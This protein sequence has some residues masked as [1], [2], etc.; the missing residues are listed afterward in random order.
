VLAGVALAAGALALGGC[1]TLTRGTHGPFRIVST[2][3]GAHVQLSSGET[4]VTP[5]TLD[6]PR[7]N[8]FEA[9]LTLAGYVTQTLSVTSRGS[10]VGVIG[11]L[12]NGVIGGMAGAGSDMDSGALRSLSPNPLVVRFDPVPSPSTPISIPPTMPAP[13]SAT[14][15]SPPVGASLPASHEER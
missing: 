15:S 13:A 10:T 7:A 9:R 8:S 14:S 5:C 2:P 12:G 6:L 11:L 1:A 4:C 3:A